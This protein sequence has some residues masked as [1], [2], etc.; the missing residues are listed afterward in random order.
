MRLPQTSVQ[1]KNLS[2]IVSTCFPANRDF[3]GYGWVWLAL[4]PGVKVWLEPREGDTELGFCL[5]E[6]ATARDALFD[7]EVNL[8]EAAK[9]LDHLM[10]RSEG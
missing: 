6:G 4:T 3:F 8:S 7:A 5:G 1:N 2:R 10:L 9:Q